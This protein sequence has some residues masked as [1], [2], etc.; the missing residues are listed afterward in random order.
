MHN[1]E[2]AEIDFAKFRQLMNK[3]NIC[4]RI[5]Q[6]TDESVTV[7]LKQE[8]HANQAKDIINRLQIS[9]MKA[10]DETKHE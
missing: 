6:K 1:I 5:T 4:F 2:V 8:N 10:S 7:S 3:K 9:R